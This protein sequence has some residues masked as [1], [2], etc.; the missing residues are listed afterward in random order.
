MKQ[1]GWDNPYNAN[2]IQMMFKAYENGKGLPCNSLESFKTCGTHT[3]SSV[4]SN[5][6]DL[7]YD[8][9]GVTQ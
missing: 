9:K 5:K 7:F 3:I 2:D 6:N 8:I 1:V 4:I